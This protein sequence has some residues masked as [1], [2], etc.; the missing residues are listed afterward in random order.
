[1]LFRS[2]R[3]FQ[4]DDWDDVQLTSSLRLLHN[5]LKLNI[6]PEWS[7]SIDDYRNMRE[8]GSTGKAYDQHIEV[9]YKA[10]CYRIIGTYRY[11]GYDRS[12]SL[13]VELPG[14]FD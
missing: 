4:Y 8:G 5:N 2:R 1:M 12:Y 14:I 10:Q 3:K 13:M 9:A 11:D 6:S 7:I